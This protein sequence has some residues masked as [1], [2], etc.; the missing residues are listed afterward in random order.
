MQTF[1]TANF[2]KDKPGHAFPQFESLEPSETQAIRVS[3][4]ARLGLSPA[5]N[6]LELA[7]CVDQRARTLPD[8][9]AEDSSFDLAGALSAEGI[10]P[11]PNV[12]VN[13]Y[14]FDEIDRMSFGDLA[15]NFDDVWYP[16]SDDID[17]FDDSVSWILSVSHEG[18]VKVLKLS[19]K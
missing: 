17:I 9:D 10:R 6:S 1:K 3:L 13:W 4:G 14:R 12:Y 11:R 15:A 7:R 2:K 8:M 5:A 16:S 18:A 19:D